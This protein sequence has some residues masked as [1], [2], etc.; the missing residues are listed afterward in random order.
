[1]ST[2]VLKLDKYEVIISEYFDILFIIYKIKLGN[3]YF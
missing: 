2:Q 3:L 1:M